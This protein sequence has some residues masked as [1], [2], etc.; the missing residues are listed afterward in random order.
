MSEKWQLV[1]VC[2]GKKYGQGELE[3]LH[4]AAKAFSPTHK[5][6][7]VLV[8]RPKAMLNPEIEQVK[9]PDFY[10]QEQFLAAGCQAKLAIFEKGML[11]PDLKAVYVDLDSFILGDLGIIAQMTGNE[12]LATMPANAIGPSGFLRL[13]FRLTSGRVS[14]RGNGSLICFMPSQNYDIAEAFRTRFASEG[15]SAKF[16]RADDRFYS[17]FAQLRL[18]FIAPRYAVKFSQEYMSHSLM[19]LKVWSA[20][21]GTRK[22]RA[23]QLFLTFV[24][25]QISPKVLLSLPNDGVVED[26]RGRKT[27]WN[28][29]VLGDLKTN[30]QRWIA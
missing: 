16:M 15:L 13:L 27:I 10:L 28:E 29:K 7:V 12:T 18:R 4:N 1:L 2:W 25:D 5:K 3:R 11:H 9:I 26:R 20:L 19:L 6:T 17:H 23:Q 14:T 22:R 24:G 21:P 30:L 8:D